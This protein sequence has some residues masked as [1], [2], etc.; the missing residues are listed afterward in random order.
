MSRMTK[1]VALNLIVVIGTILGCA[2]S[3][4]LNTPDAIDLML[5]KQDEYSDCY[6]HAKTNKGGKIAVQFYV[7][8]TGNASDT[9]FV[10]N[11]IHDREVEQCIL[12]TLLSTQFPTNSHTTHQRIL[13]LLFKDKV[14]NEK[15]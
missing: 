12:G 15:Q 4:T 9:K 3:P 2:S 7:N 13:T 5:L 14:D 6:Y 10:E 1:W 8:K 11:S